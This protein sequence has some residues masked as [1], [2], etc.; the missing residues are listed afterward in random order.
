MKYGMHR[1]FSTAAVDAIM[2]FDFPGNVRELENM[3]ERTMLFAESNIIHPDEV[4]A[5][6]DEMTDTPSDESGNPTDIGASPTLTTQLENYEKQILKGYFK[7][8][9]TTMRMAEVL[10]VDQSTISRKLRKYGL[11]ARSL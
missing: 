2:R 9:G 8:C 11:S 1:E 7:S 3:T 6:R 4:L 5:N 10:G